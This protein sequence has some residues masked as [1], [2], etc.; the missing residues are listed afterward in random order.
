[1]QTS[2]TVLKVTDN[3]YKYISRYEIEA[4]PGI[5]EQLELLHWMVHLKWNVVQHLKDKPLN[6]FSL[7]VDV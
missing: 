2:S 5:Q 3:K 7:R 6:D 1:M 4:C